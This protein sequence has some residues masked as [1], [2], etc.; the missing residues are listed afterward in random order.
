MQDTGFLHYRSPINLDHFLF[1][2]LLLPFAEGFFPVG[3]RF[4]LTEAVLPAPC[5][6]AADFFF[7]GALSSSS[8]PFR[9]LP[10][11]TGCSAS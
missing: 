4:F 6:I 11:L 1:W 7:L 10:I 5:L 9:F 3:F 8:S 2:P